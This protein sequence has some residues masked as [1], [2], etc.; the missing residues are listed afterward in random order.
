M[1]KRKLY[2]ENNTINNEFDKKYYQKD[3]KLIE[4]ENKGKKEDLI[5]YSKFIQ[6]VVSEI[7]FARTKPSE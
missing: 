6:E 5:I 2:G 7:N 3:E 1:R 4:D